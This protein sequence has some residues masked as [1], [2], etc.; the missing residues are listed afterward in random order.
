M[1]LRQISL[2]QS[3]TKCCLGTVCQNILEWVVF[4]LMPVTPVLRNQTGA[5]TTKWLNTMTICQW[6]EWKRTRPFSQMVKFRMGQVTRTNHFL[7]G[8]IIQRTVWPLMCGRSPSARVC[9]EKLKKKPWH[10]QHTL[11]GPLLINLLMRWGFCL[12]RKNRLS[13]H[14]FWPV[15]NM[16]SSHIE[17]FI[18][19]Q[20]K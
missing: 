2:T 6:M 8:V 18:L 14:I 10:T 11:L 13:L 7:K 17:G 16:I 4:V 20:C 5:T 12:K 1:V 15:Y 9:C 19:F 3:K